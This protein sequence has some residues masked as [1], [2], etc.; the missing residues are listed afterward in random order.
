VVESVRVAATFTAALT[1]E[2]V[3]R[4]LLHG[5]FASGLLDTSVAS[6]PPAPLAAVLCQA[7]LTVA[8]A[9]LL[10]AVVFFLGAR[11]VIAAPLILSK[12]AIQAAT[13]S[14]ALATLIAGALALLLARGSR[15][16]RTAP[17]APSG[18]PEVISSMMKQAAITKEVTLLAV[19]VSIALS[20]TFCL[21]AMRG[22][23]VEPRT[24]AM[25]SVAGALVGTY[26]TL[27]GV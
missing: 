11:R 5:A 21:L 3:G 14:P 12:T 7:F 27:A 2:T 24:V 4:L 16:I 20:V 17:L 13:T 25:V 9:A 8:R 6:A 15:P 1:L 18:L 26:S 10:Y 23:C 22:K 19:A